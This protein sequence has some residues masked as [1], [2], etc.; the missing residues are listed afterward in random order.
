MMNIFYIIEGPDKYFDE[1]IKESE[2][3]SQN[4]QHIYFRDMISVI[5]DVSLDSVIQRLK[6]Q[7]VEKEL[8]LIVKTEDFSSLNEHYVEKLFFQMVT[9]LEKEYIYSIAVQNPPTVFLD[10]IK[11]YSSTK[12]LEVVHQQYQLPTINKSSLKEIAINLNEKIIGQKQIISQIIAALYLNINKVENL[13]IVLMFYG[14]PGVGKTESAN[15]I[16]NAINGTE[17]FRQQ[18]SMFK[19]MEFN[20][21]IF[22]A[23]LQSKSLTRDLKKNSSNVILFDEFNQCPEYIYSAFFQMFDEG[24]YEDINY[25]VSLTNSII[26][27]TSN[28]ETVEEIKN[29]LG[30]ALFSRFTHLIKFNNLDISSKEKLL[31]RYYE[32]IIRDFNQEDQDLIE[33]LNL[34]EKILDFVDSFSNVRNI[35]NGIRMFISRVLAEHFLEEV[36]NLEEVK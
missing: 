33:A 16:S 19:T 27:C 28:Y 23:K 32:E 29:K 17:A 2:A 6:E 12:N 22:G 20:D 26:I 11:N 10:S 14:P 21:Y 18:M 9:W 7:H 1:C 3:E 4:T 31:K 34:K 25:S 8:L 13:P 5:N 24:F 36:L 35:K 15:I 30:P